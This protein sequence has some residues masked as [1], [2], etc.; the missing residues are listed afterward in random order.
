MLVRA[1]VVDVV[2]A[3]TDPLTGGRH[4]SIYPKSSTTNCILDMVHQ[5]KHI[6]PIINTT[7]ESNFEIRFLRFRYFTRTI[8]ARLMELHAV[9]S[10]VEF[11][12]VEDDDAGG[13]CCC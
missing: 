1:V 7:G 5:Y 2:D 10:S 13:G 12:N 8:A 4:D 11:G 6:M 9:T 3:T